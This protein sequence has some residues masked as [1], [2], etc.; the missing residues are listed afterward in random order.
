MLHTRIYNIL[1][2]TIVDY[3]HFI[4]E[5]AKVDLKLPVF[6][7]G[8]VLPFFLNVVCYGSSLDTRV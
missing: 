5:I 2:I 3:T 7:L 1:T 8:L 6:F 4:K